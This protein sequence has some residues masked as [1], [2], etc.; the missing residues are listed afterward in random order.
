VVGGAAAGAVPAR[1][2]VPTIRGDR[3]M[4]TRLERALRLDGA[5]AQRL[6]ALQDDLLANAA[7]DVQRLAADDARLAADRRAATVARRRLAA[8]A[9]AEYVD[10]G[11]TPGPLAL[12][13]EGATGP[14]STQGVVYAEA[15]AGALVALV[16]AYRAAAGRVVVA[17]ARLGRQ[18]ALTHAELRRAR[19]ARAAADAAMRTEN[20]L[21]AGVRR[22]LRALVLAAARRATEDRDEDELARDPAVA[23]AKLAAPLERLAGRTAL[24]DGAAG[25]SPLPEPPLGYADPLRAIR[26]LTPERIDQGVD[27]SGYGPIYALGDGVVLS[28]ENRGWPGRSYIAYELTS[29]PAA[30]LTVYAA[31]DIDPRVTVGQLV[32]SRTVL[33][34]VYEGPNGIETGWADGGSGDTMAMA[35]R[36]F[37]G[38]NST[39]FGSNFSELLQSLG[40]P[41]GVLRGR[42][43][44]GM[45]PA[46]WP[47][48]SAAAAAAAGEARLLAR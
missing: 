5:R 19:A 26:A 2:H 18:L 37:D 44:S 24:E 15:A 31:E 21:L 20:D 47:S 28:T 10:A 40:A 8:A 7:G 39:A 30:G 46:D 3:A 38:T 48:W 22:N 11:S 34:T 14:G 12:S 35:A 43:P 13:P 17:R 33:G 25:W 1:R 41:G 9:V 6:V 29:G 16:D 32:T 45:L 23:A 27:Y 42:V 36:Q 4:I